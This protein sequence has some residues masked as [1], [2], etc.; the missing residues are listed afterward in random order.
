MTRDQAPRRLNILVVDDNEDDVLLLEESF[1]DQPAV[2]VICVVHD[3][4]EALSFLG[5][6]ARLHDLRWNAQGIT[7][8]F[9]ATRAMSFHRKLV[10]HST[11]IQEDVGI[12]IQLAEIAGDDE[13]SVFVVEGCMRIVAVIAP[14]PVVEPRA[15]EV[16]LD[17]LREL[18]E[19]FL[20]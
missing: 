17:H 9:T 20:R 18:A 8:P 13:A 11:G 7:S 10:E 12:G 15:P 14:S 6:L 1:R 16:H 5:E 4:D 3:G 2:N 19:R